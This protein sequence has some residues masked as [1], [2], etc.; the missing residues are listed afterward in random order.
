MNIAWQPTR[1]YIDRAELT[2]FLAATKCATFDDMQSKASQEAAFR[3]ACL[4][5]DP[6]DLTVLDNP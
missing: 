5:E 4:G 6:G 1:E 3:A 2:R